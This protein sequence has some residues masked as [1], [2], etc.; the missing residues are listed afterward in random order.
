MKIL[1]VDDDRINRFLIKKILV[2]EL[3]AEVAEADN[4]F[5]ALEVLASE[6]NFDLAVLDM[7]MPGM[8][9]IQLLEK[10]RLN[11]SLRRMK[12]VMCSAL[13]ER[14]RIAQAYA[15]EIQ[16]YILKPVQS[17]KLVRA[18]KMAL[19]LDERQVSAATADKPRETDLDKYMD[20]LSSL[21]R[22]TDCHIQLLRKSSS[23]GDRSAMADTLREIMAGAA[24]LGIS[25]M[26]KLAEQFQMN[27]FQCNDDALEKHIELL[28]IERASL[29]Q[30]LR[31][32][33]PAASLEYA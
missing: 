18:I 7:M 14:L 1:T 15:L 2:H 9:G 8:D 28:A 20:Q 22:Q 32:V 29:S 5:K 3:K 19:H 23:I 27:V 33:R 11:Y 16:D 30:T 25:R 17:Q 4:G 26:A 10:I 21:A 31:G 13:N 12:I 24:N 6:P